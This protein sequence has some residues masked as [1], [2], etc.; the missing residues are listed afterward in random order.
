MQKKIISIVGQI[1]NIFFLLLINRFFYQEFGLFFLGLYNAAVIFTQFILIF[2]D[3][4]ISSGLTNQISKYKFSNKDYV[5][6]IAQSGL[7]IS[8]FIFIIFIIFVTFFLQNKLISEFLKIKNIDDF[9]II[10]FLIIGMLI[11]I[12]RNQ[13]GSIL[14]GFNLPH[15]WSYLNLF[16][17]FINLIG[18]FITLHF[19]FS[20]FT[21]GYVF[22]LTNLFSLGIFIIF[23]FKN[24][25]PKILLINFHY[26][27]FKKILNFSTKIYIGSLI[28]FFSSFIDRILVFSVISINILGIYSIIHNVSQKIEVIGNSIAVTIFPELSADSNKS[29]ELFI[30]N[31]KNWI[32]F[33]NFAS[34]NAAIL[35]F[36]A[37]DYIYYFVFNEF[38]DF[39]IKLIFLIIIL[40][41][42]TKSICN[43][44]IWV[45]S[46]INKPEIQIYYGIINFV[47]YLIMIVIY[48]QSISINI[49][50]YSFLLSNTVSLMFLIIYL[51]KSL[52]NYLILTIFV[53][54]VKY[55]VCSIILMSM[56]YFIIYLKLNI[57]FTSIFTF[58][59]YFFS[60]LFLLLKTN[61]LN[62]YKNNEIIKY[63]LSKTKII[64]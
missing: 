30:N 11:A 52:N 37:S 26:Q 63:I 4:G 38:P 34:F 60:I 20:N 51:I 61:F 17:N 22:I 14:M 3:F 28:S 10:Y 45:I 2:S 39:E 27:S 15:I 58:T 35:I 56:I 9:S 53:D 64:I 12:P 54:F 43:L 6:K 8:I 41:Y 32:E 5:I 47:T 18:L 46:S 29:K 33:T 16:T 48:Y 21:I 55:F 57:H 25:F 44:I 1:I 59:I 13:L 19:G 7:F 23:V 40:S 31:I 50:A 36:F 42:F 62:N 49:I 24:T